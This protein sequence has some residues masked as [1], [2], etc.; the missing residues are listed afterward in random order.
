M[1][2]YG[3]A[4][5]PKFTKKVVPVGDYECRVISALERTNE[6][7]QAYIEFQFKVREDVQ[8]ECQGYTLTKK[9]KPD[10]NGNYKANKI[11]EFAF[12]C[13]VAEGEDYQIEELTGACVIVHVSQFPSRDSGEMISYVSYLKESQV[14]DTSKP[15][16]ADEFD[17]MSSDDIPF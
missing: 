6:D 9:F 15:L 10:D 8:Q 4:S 12:A 17:T 2:Y 7:G 13:G 3:K 16:N 14:G 5:K 11:D 1:S